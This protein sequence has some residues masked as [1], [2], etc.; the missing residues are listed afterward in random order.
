MNNTPMQFVFSQSEYEERCVQAKAL[1]VGSIETA[2][3]TYVTGAIIQEHIQDATKG[4]ERYHELRKAGY[5][6]LP[7]IS[8]LQSFTAIGYM[9]TLYMVK[10]Q[11]MQDSDLEKICEQVKADYVKS[12]D[13]AYEAH[14]QHQ[15]E[16][17]VVAEKRQAERDRILAEEGIATRV[18]EDML[19]ARGTLQR[20][21]IE[22]GKLTEG[23]YAQ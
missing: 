1:Y 10:P 6:T 18:R 15:I 17:A 23:G 21:L 7:E 3:T 12:L 16:L 5:T 14:V 11:K 22:Q 13:D 4:A 20:K 19:A 9:V 2:A 8:P